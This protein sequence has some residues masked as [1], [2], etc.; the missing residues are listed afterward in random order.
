MDDIKHCNAVVYK[1]LENLTL[2]NMVSPHVKYAD[3]FA[4]QN[5]RRGNVNA[6]AV[7]RS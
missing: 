1:I 5:L 4:S 2:L 6:S 7:A 3:A